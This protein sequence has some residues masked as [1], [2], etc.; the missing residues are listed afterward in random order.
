MQHSLEVV[1]TAVVFDFAVVYHAAGVDAV[2]WET[3][4]AELVCAVLVADTA[5]CSDVEV[6]AGVVL[7]C[8]V[9]TVALVVLDCTVD[10]VLDAP[11][12][13]TLGDIGVVS[14]CTVCC[15]GVGTAFAVAY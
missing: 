13:C 5:A 14:D 6:D 4:D 3:V 2:V 11:V 9:D 1:G 10:I 8:T 7:E 15:C 12:C